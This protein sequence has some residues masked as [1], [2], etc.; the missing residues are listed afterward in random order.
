VGEPELVRRRF[1]LLEREN[2]LRDER[3]VAA[4]TKLPRVSVPAHD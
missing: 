2:T 3:I 1:E 4:L